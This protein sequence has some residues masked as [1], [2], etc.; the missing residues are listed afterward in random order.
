MKVEQEVPRSQ[1]DKLR[2]P[3]EIAHLNPVLLQRT[4]IGDNDAG[5]R[6]QYGNPTKKNQMV[7]KVRH[8]NPETYAKLIQLANDF[9]SQG[10]LYN[11]VRNTFGLDSKQFAAVVSN[12]QLVANIVSTN[13]TAGKLQFD[14]QPRQALM[15][16]FESVQVN[17]ADPQI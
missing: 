11:Y 16:Q 1:M 2:P 5:G 3:T 7:E 17:C 6:V 15:G 10:P 8:M 4:A 12:T 14:L 13:C 9:K